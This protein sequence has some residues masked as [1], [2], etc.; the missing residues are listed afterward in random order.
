MTHRWRFSE[1]AD[2]REIK[3]L[4]EAMINI[5]TDLHVIT[6]IVGSAEAKAAQIS[7]SLRK[8]LFDQRSE[9]LLERC[10]EDMKLHPLQTKEKLQDMDG[11][12][13]GARF[14]T[15][16]GGNL[17]IEEVDRN[18]GEP[19][20]R[21]FRFHPMQCEGGFLVKPMH[22]I[23]L[24]KNTD[25]FHCH[26]PFETSRDVELID[27]KNWLNTDLVKFGK[28]VFKVRDVLRQ[29]A[30]SEGAHAT[31]WWEEEGNSLELASRFKFGGASYSHIFTLL[32]AIYICRMIRQAEDVQMKIPTWVNTDKRTIE[33]ANVK[34]KKKYAAIAQQTIK[35]PMYLG[36]VPYPHLHITE[37]F[38]MEAA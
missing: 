5:S 15:A 32:T 12:S 20:G 23:I 38:V 6:Q 35:L 26:N 27:A 14:G 13:M 37:S 24:D 28:D 2:S 21:K 11:G 10:I 1:N 4:E 31:K 22:G 16:G 30:N 19:I 33:P 9:S 3:Q 18:T 25:A 36:L 17:D 29:V 7:V 34:V 8:L